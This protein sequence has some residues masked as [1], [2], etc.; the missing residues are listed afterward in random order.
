M[1][2]APGPPPNT[3]LL[4]WPAATGVLLI[5]L[6]ATFLAWQ[7]VGENVRKNEQIRFDN[8]VEAAQ[9]AIVQR[10]DT[11][12][13]TL[14]S[15]AAH[16]AASETTT[17]ESWRTYVRGLELERL[18]PG[19][20]GIGFSMR[21]AA[22]EVGAHEARI[23]AGGLPGY[24]VQPA[25]PPRD[26][27]YPIVYLEP[28]D[29]RNWRAVGYD[30]YSE[31]RRRE[32]MA[33]AR[34]TG[35]PAMTGK[36]QL[37]QETDQAPQAGFLIY[38]PVYQP[39]MPT[40][41]IAERRA[42]LL[43]FTYSPFRAD[44]L[45][46]N[47]FAGQRFAFI[48][49]EIYDR[50]VEPE[51]LL[52]DHNPVY[53]GLPASGPDF[54]R[55]NDVTIAGHPWRI[56]FTSL[57]A[58]DDDTS[59]HLPLLVLL[60]GLVIS[61]LLAGITLVVA[62]GRVRAEA[63]VAL[64]TRELAE[65]NMQLRRTD[66]YKDEFLGIMSHELRTP[67]NFIMSFASL[68]EEEVSG[69]LNPQQ[70]THATKILDGADR[71]LKIVEDLLDVATIQAGKVTLMTAP[72]DYGRLLEQVVDELRPLAARKHI[73][74]G[75]EAAPLAPMPLDRLRIQQVLTNLISNAIKFTPEGG[76][77]TVHA[78]EAEGAVLTEVSDT[79]CGIAEHELE[80]IFERFHQADMS[81]TRQAGGTGLGLAIAKA[82]VEAHDG[83][84]GVRSRPG[85]GSTFFFTLPRGEAP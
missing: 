37:V 55:F 63:E 21:L 39:G 44:D 75:L 43:G 11:Y 69:P 10:M 15:A 32:A 61:V 54:H 4:G 28:M 42:A 38:V 57:P 81:P 33:R 71:M 8:R 59:Q 62:T 47:L 14:R 24:S 35:Q 80:R 17:R 25:S 64:R 20:Q 79:G 84:I 12:I 19:L 45:F 65:A 82:L 76:T 18:Y 67:L 72:E 30:M 2:H 68:L 29:W 56:A 13:H 1:T 49:F 77:I 22:S 73:A 6:L 7:V 53:D 3:R 16:Y 51:N 46:E 48:G 66:R 31:P 34:D 5:A 70:K 83:A 58:F 50:A 74:L 40:S 85:E 78:T 60:G 41:T 9:E 52:H 36:V 27:Y 26:T 23:R